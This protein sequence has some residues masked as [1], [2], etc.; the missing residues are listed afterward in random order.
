MVGTIGPLDTLLSTLGDVPAD[1][2]F[3]RK[4]LFVR[5]AHRFSTGRILLVV[6]LKW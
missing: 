3:L 6:V 5:P 4:K 1:D 2:C